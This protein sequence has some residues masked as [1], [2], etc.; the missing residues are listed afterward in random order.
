MCCPK[1]SP[2][3]IDELENKADLSAKEVKQT[4]TE[5]KQETTSNPPAKP[6][7]TLDNSDTIT[8][9]QQDL[10]AQ[11]VS[12]DKQPLSSELTKEDSKTDK[13][14]LSSE[15]TKKESKTEEQPL[16]SPPT[17]ED[18]KTEEQS[19]FSTEDENKTQTKPESSEPTKEDGKTEEQSKSSTE[20][21]NKAETK[22]ESS[23]PTKEDGK[24]GEQ[25]ESPIKEDGKTGEQLES[26][27]KEGDKT[28]E[29]SESSAKEDGKTSEVKDKKTKSK[30]KKKDKKPP[31][32]KYKILAGN[33]CH[34]GIAE[35]QGILVPPIDDEGSHQLI[36]PDGLALE[37]TF[38]HNYLK[39]LAFNQPNISG[40]HWFRG[41][42]KMQDNKLVAL[43]I[44]G[45]D[46]NM[47]TNE[48]GWEKWE[49]IGVWTIQKNLTVQRSMGDK[50][51]K[52]QAIKTGY[53]KK[54]KF[55]FSNSEDWVKQ[56]KL[57]IGYVYQLICRREGD[58]LKIQKVIPYACPRFKPV[59][60]PKKK[61][62]NKDK[63]GEQSPPKLKDKSS[64][65]ISPKSNDKS[66]E[67]ILPKSVDFKGVKKEEIAP[68]AEILNSIDSQHQTADTPTEEKKED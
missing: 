29:Q 47:P 57:W 6:E 40:A 2:I 33:G 9:K 17:K 1:T 15:L 44:V 49:F 60:K 66:S 67:Q 68:T 42:P 46:G 62:L 18:G 16:S 20:D 45:W 3:N 26:S 61:T 39:W 59:A 31:A 53:I 52:E 5:D 23:E 21:E 64:E 32:K 10:F 55:T 24:T 11:L 8:P 28:S 25:S 63:S 7:E 35:V 19:K 43:Q 4:T 58:T 27:A 38:A 36:L 22:P 12:T 54:F 14:S 48:K 65:Q 13:Q 41:Y 34:Q 50:D 30:K 37:A 51:V 56:K